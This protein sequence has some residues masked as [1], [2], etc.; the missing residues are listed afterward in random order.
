MAEIGDKTFTFKSFAKLRWKTAQRLCGATLGYQKL[1]VASPT[2]PCMPLF[3]RFAMAALIRPGHAVICSLSGDT[4]TRAPC[5][6]RHQRTASW[7]QG[8]APPQE[9][10]LNHCRPCALLQSLLQGARARKSAAEARKRSSE[11]KPSAG[12]TKKRHQ[13]D[14]TAPSRETPKAQVRKAAAGP[15]TRGGRPE[16][17]ELPKD[18]GATAAGRHSAFAHEGRRADA[19]RQ[20]VARQQRKLPPHTPPSTPI[21]PWSTALSA[22]GCTLVATPGGGP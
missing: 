11:L 18:L 10:R 17:E 1:A 5:K 3:S 12:K 4:V 16:R 2:H 9:A 14:G 6:E 21:H 7:R 20:A 13:R 22:G 15:T 8:H 19:A